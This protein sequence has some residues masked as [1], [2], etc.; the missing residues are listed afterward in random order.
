MKYAVHTDL[1]VLGIGETEDAALVDALI[2]GAEDETLLNLALITDD[3]AAYVEAGGDCRGLTL[4][5]NFGDDCFRLA[6]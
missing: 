5:D 6:R 1:L 2:H 3:A 4:G